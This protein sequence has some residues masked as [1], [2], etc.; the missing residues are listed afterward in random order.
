MATSI[1]AMVAATALSGPVG[2]FVAVAVVPVSRSIFG[3]FVW[4]TLFTSLRLVALEN[5]IA[6]SSDLMSW[7][8]LDQ[9][10]Q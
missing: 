3:V 5:M 8:D 7:P 6:E 9:A 1:E 2:L 4:G 10:I